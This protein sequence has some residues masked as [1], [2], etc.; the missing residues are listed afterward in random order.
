MKR[1]PL[2]FKIPGASMVVISSVV[3]STTVVIVSVVA[4]VVAGVF[5]SLQTK[6]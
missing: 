6:G 5:E 2:L 3:V 4:V 1:Q